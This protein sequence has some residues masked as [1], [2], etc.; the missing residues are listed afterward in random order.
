[1]DSRDYMVGAVSFAAGIAAGAYGYKKYQEWKARQPAPAPQTTAPATTPPSGY[2]P[3]G[4]AMYY[5]A[6]AV[7]A[8][9]HSH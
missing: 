4:Q 5:P 9:A 3:A 2:L 7:P 6:G 8:H 1:M